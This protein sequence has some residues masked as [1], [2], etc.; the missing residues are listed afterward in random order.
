MLV[1]LPTAASQPAASCGLA[2]PGRPSGRPLVPPGIPSCLAGLPTAASAELFK[3]NP[4]SLGELCRDPSHPQDVLPPPNTS[5]CGVL[6][7]NP[8]PLGRGNSHFPGQGQL[9]RPSA[10]LIRRLHWVGSPAHKTRTDWNTPKEVVTAESENHAETT[11]LGAG[12]RL[13]AQRYLQCYQ[14]AMH[15]KH[16]QCYVSLISQLEK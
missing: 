13:S 10:W 7:G 16:T 8:S 9:L 11:V 5:H 3:A 1:P 12:E 2:E 4:S 14:H 6:T 15:L